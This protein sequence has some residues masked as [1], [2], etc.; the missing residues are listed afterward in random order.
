MIDDVRT[1][2]ATVPVG[3]SSLAFDRLAGELQRWHPEADVLDCELLVGPLLNGLV[4]ISRHW[5]ARMEQ[6]VEADAREDW[7][8]LLDR[9]IGSV[10]SGDWVERSGCRP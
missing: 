5:I 4:V 6:G 10:R 3:D 7:E 8:A 1:A 9:R 2:A